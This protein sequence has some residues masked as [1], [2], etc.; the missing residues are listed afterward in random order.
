MKKAR[1]GRAEPASA[2]R[3]MPVHCKNRTSIGDC[4]LD[5]I[6]CEAHFSANPISICLYFS[7]KHESGGRATCDKEACIEANKARLYD[8]IKAEWTFDDGSLISMIR[9]YWNVKMGRENIAPSNDALA[10]TLLSSRPFNAIDPAGQPEEKLSR[11]MQIV[12]EFCTAVRS[13]KYVELDNLMGF[14]MIY[15]HFTR[16]FEKFAG[17]GSACFTKQCYLGRYDRDMCVLYNIDH[18]RSEGRVV[19]NNVGLDVVFHDMIRNGIK[20][21]IKFEDTINPLSSDLHDAVQNLFQNG[22]I[23]QPEHSSIRITD[24]GKLM[25]EEY[26]RDRMENDTSPTAIP[27]VPGARAAEQRRDMHQSAVQRDVAIINTIN[28][29]KGVIAKMLGIGPGRRSRPA[30]EEEVRC[31]RCANFTPPHDCSKHH[32][33]SMDDKGAYMQ[34]CSDFK[35]RIAIK[36]GFTGPDTNFPDIDDHSSRYYDRDDHVLRDDD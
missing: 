13:G 1:N 4:K 35:S 22:L 26:R 20:I 3:V 10:R 16:E 8:A 29:K 19:G 31:A 17:T 25:L 28:A 15:S 7:D 23:V 5:K 36:P 32:A 34:G 18:L 11:L 33:V 27:P 6:H 12:R 30:P 14:R 2:S 9:R 21:D 24:G